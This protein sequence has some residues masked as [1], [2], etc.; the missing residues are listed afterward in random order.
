MFFK[1]G[2]HYHKTCLNIH[3]FLFPEVKNINTHDH[4]SFNRIHTEQKKHSVERQK[5]TIFSIITF[6]LTPRKNDRSEEIF[7]RYGDIRIARK[8]AVAA[9]IH[10]FVITALSLRGRSRRRI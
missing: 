3:L 9:I 2:M 5:N 6:V 10:K 8:D 1:V 7:L 4:V